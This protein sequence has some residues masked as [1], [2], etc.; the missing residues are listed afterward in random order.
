MQASSHA[1]QILIREGHGRR[2]RGVHLGPPERAW[3]AV[4]WFAGLVAAMGAADLLIWWLPPRPL[5]REWLFAALAATL[6]GLPWLSLG[7]I[8]MLGAAM[9]RRA[10]R[11]TLGAAG[12]QLVIAGIVVVALLAFL[13]L[14]PS[15][16]RAAEPAAALGFRRQVLRTLIFGLGFGAAHLA[17]G[18]LALRAV[19]R[20]E[21]PAREPSAA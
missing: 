19:R 18:L 12:A 14:L 21:E 3:R 16:L 10:V 11:A 2:R 7:A 8:G 20:G 6:T 4:G 9:A 1:P 15:A 17:A 5:D 13:A